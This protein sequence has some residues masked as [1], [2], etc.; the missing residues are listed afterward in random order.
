MLQWDL[1]SGGRFMQYLWQPLRSG[2]VHMFMLCA[3]KYVE[4]YLALQPGKGCCDR[5]AGAPRTVVVA[6]VRRLQQSLL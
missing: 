4:E 3:C 1:E 6:S 2:D 5:N